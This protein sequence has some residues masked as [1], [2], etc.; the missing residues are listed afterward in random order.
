MSNEE[1]DEVSLNLRTVFSSAFVV[2]ISLLTI[3]LS[4]VIGNQSS[5]TVELNIGSSLAEEAYQMSEK[6]D[7]F[8]W[9]RSG[10]VEV[11]SKL[12]AFQ[13]PL[14][15]EETSRLLN[16]LKQSL[17]VFTWVAY[18][19]RQ[20]NV[21]SSTDNIL[22]GQNI[23]KR[24]VFV[25]GMKGTFIGDVHDAILLSKYLPNPSGE[26]LQLDRKSVV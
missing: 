13:E 9:S 22:Q 17:P 23:S 21:V 14:D 25:E 7:H 11:L 12:N 6:L 10:E 5:R 3:L 1:N 2:I 8:M 16:Q 15:K 4:Y 20:G 26:P 19:D 24:P 18:L